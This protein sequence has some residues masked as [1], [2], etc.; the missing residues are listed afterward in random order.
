[1]RRVYA[2]GTCRR[3][4]GTAGFA[5]DDDPYWGD[6]ELDLPRAERESLTDQGI[7][8]PELEERLSE[9]R[10]DT[11][12]RSPPPRGERVDTVLAPVNEEDLPGVPVPRE[13]APPPPT[14]PS[15]DAEDS[16]VE[17]GDGGNGGAE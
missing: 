12:E 17:E 6:E 13:G 2:L 7:D 16:E 15:P 3:D 10:G 11:V 1:M 4:L 9:V 14:P 8:W 5:Y